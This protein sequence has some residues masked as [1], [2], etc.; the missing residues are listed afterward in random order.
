ML[1][2][3]LSLRPRFLDVVSGDG[4]LHRWRLRFNQYGL[5][6]ITRVSRNQA[7]HV[8]GSSSAYDGML[9]SPLAFAAR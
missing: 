6:H 4:L 5:R 3:V 1:K 2:T 8:F 7:L 9:L